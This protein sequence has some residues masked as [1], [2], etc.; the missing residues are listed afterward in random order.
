MG[1]GSS[2][3]KGIDGGCTTVHTVCSSFVQS[4]AVKS[5]AKSQ[6]EH[7]NQRSRFETPFKLVWVSLPL[8]RSSSGWVSQCFFYLGHLAVL[9]KVQKKNPRRL[10]LLI[11][12]NTPHRRW[13]QGPGQRRPKVPGRFAFPGAQNPR[14]CSISRFGKIFPMIKIIFERS[15]QKGGRQGGREGGQ[16]ETHLEILLSA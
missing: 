10:E 4:L 6:T 11:S 8:L 12:K 3:Q 7:R 1:L 15:S 14:I 2:G 5:K 16:Q 9:E 13:G